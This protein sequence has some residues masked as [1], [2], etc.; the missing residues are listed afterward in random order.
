MVFLHVKKFP[1]RILPVW[2]KPFAIFIVFGTGKHCWF[3][4]WTLT[5]DSKKFSVFVMIAQSIRD[6]EKENEKFE[7]QLRK[8]ANDALLV[9]LASDLERRLEKQNSKENLEN[10]HTCLQEASNSSQYANC[11]FAALEKITSR[12]GQ[13]T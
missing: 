9:T 2:M 5:R 11:I 1:Y 3:Q 7:L 10:M 12:Q 4:N 8:R 6:S 13:G